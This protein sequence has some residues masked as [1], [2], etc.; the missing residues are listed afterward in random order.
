MQ[1]LQGRLAGS[2]DVFAHLAERFL[3]GAAD[4][5]EGALRQTDEVLIGRFER[6]IRKALRL[7]PRSGC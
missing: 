4:V 6:G 1:S 5:S 3:V 2:R 7:F